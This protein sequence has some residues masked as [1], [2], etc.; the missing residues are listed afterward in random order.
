M[1]APAFF[2]PCPEVS[3]TLSEAMGISGAALSIANGRVDG[4]SGVRQFVNFF[5]AGGMGRWIRFPI[6]KGDLVHRASPNN[7]AT[8][9]PNVKPT[10]IIKTSTATE[11]AIE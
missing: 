7:S 6:R 10:H 3:I 2:V 8:K 11:G 1:G 5:A 9:A 4:R